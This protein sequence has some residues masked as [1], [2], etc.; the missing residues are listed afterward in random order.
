MRDEDKMRTFFNR[1]WE[2]AEELGSILQ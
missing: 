1:S 2:F